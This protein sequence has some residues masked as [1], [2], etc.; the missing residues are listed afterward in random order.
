MPAPDAD[1]SRA[2]IPASA[3]DNPAITEVG[4]AAL[5]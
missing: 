1:A 5:K 4:L 3:S 2:V